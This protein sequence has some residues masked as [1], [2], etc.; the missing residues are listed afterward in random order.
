M[1]ET[2]QILSVIRA[3]CIA[4]AGRIRNH[5]CMDSYRP[6]EP[7]HKSSSEIQS[8]L[9]SFDRATILQIYFNRLD[10]HLP[11]RIPAEVADLYAIDL[12]TI[13]DFLLNQRPHDPIL[14]Q[15]LKSDF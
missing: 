10:D 2:K 15:I 1:P 4:I 14:H 8:I 12:K 11:A 7:I 5:I 6:L 3:E 9:A 13:K